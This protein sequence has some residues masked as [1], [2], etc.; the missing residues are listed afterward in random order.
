MWDVA[1]Q[2]TISVTQLT[3]YRRLVD[4]LGEVSDHA[5]SAVDLE[6]K[7]LVDRALAD[8]LEMRAAED[9]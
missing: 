4:F 7:E 2:V 3:Q 5:H 9:E 6:L 8:L 1:S